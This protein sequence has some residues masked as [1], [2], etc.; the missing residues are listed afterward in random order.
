MVTDALFKHFQTIVN[1]S[2]PFILVYDSKL[3][4]L[5]K[6][7]HF[8]KV[9]IFYFSFCIFNG[10]P[11]LFYILYCIKTKTLSTSLMAIQIVLFSTIA[12]CILLGLVCFYTLFGTNE[13]V[14]TLFNVVSA[15]HRRTKSK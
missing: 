5:Q 2:P 15:I 11:T 12:L 8:Y 9:G 4:T 3:N 6:N 13:N 7:K 14:F 1:L 10:S